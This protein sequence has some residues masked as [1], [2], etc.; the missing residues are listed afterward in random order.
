M[1]NIGRWAHSHG[2]MV[3][4]HTNL[5]VTVVFDS[6]E[7]IRS[8]DDDSKGSKHVVTIKNYVNLTPVLLILF[9]VL[10]M[11]RSSYIL[12]Y[13]IHNRMQIIKMKPIVYKP[14]NNQVFSFVSEYKSKYTSLIASEA[15][16]PDPPVSLRSQ[17]CLNRSNKLMP[18]SLYFPSN[19]H[20]N[21]IDPVIAPACV[22]EETSYCAS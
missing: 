16:T 18:R 15:I 22:L 5:S 2:S 3:V 11:V 13:G 1:L 14:Y 7:L 21:E 19:L 8:P 20:G 4:S 17:L 10:L 9:I 6:D 12:V